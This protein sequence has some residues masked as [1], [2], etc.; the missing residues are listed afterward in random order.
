MLNTLATSMSCGLCWLARVLGLEHG[1]AGGSIYVWRLITGVACLVSMPVAHSLLMGFS[2]LG[3]DSR[4]LLL[5]DW[6][7]FSV[8]FSCTWSSGGTGVG[9]M[10]VSWFA[11]GSSETCLGDVVVLVRQGPCRLMRRGPRRLVLMCEALSLAP[12]VVSFEISA[13]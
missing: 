13:G 10:V 1:K 8:A 9:L 2:M 12:D 6:V 11:L 5:S 7:W 3:T 4:Q